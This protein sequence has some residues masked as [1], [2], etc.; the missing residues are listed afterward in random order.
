MS[1][2]AGRNARAL[3][4][5]LVV[6]FASPVAWAQQVVSLQVGGKDLRVEVPDGYLRMSVDQPTLFDIAKAAAPPTNRVVEGFVS[7]ADA[8]R[9]LMGA[10]AEQPSYQVQVLH[11]AEAL[12]FSAA[13]WEEL[14]PM[15]AKTL[16]EIDMGTMTDAQSDAGAKRLGDVLGTKVTMNFGDIGKPVVYQAT[17]DSVR[18][19]MLVPVA[20]S[21]AG[22]QRQLVVECAG[23]ALPLAG[24]VVFL[25][26][27]RQHADGEDSSISRTALDHFAERAIALNQAG[28]A[29]PATAPAT[30]P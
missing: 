16:G 2:N 5:A 14:R 19:V 23:A 17:G 10:P 21:S 22:I 26:V 15:L 3:A 30:S 12:D 28:A 27:Y 11:N 25:Y 29:A 1:G 18:F 7:T 8:K 9:M 20:V 24:K 6:L 4:F 13:D